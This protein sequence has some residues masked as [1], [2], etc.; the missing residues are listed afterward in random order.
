MLLIL[1]LLLHHNLTMSC[2]A[3][4][5]TVIEFHCPSRNL[6]RNSLYKF[7]KFFR[8]G[9]TDA[10]RHY[11]CTICN[12]ELRSMLDICP[13][14]R[15]QQN[16]T[17]FIELSCTNQLREMYARPSFYD[18]LQS[19]FQ[20]PQLP[21]NITDIYD[22]QLYQEWINNGFLSN[23]HNISFTWYT[24]GVPVFKSSKISIWPLYITI[25]ELPFEDR[26]KRENT[27]LV[28]YWYN[29]EKTTDEYIF[30]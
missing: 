27:L 3:D 14:C 22:G 23:C 24:D 10:V 17:Y 11:Y 20:W 7:R 16:N 9:E 30:I 5:I 19:R 8:L 21:G 29:D 18:K 26:K 13:L 2:I 28:G 15:Q 25:N 6:R 12:R 4:I 1:S